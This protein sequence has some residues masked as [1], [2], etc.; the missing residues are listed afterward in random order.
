MVGSCLSPVNG[1]GNMFYVLMT[2][3][4]AGSERKDIDKY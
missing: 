2:V 1:G 3:F 4:Q